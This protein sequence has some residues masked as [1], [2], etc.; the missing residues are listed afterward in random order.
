MSRSRPRPAPPGP[1]STATPID[2]DARGGV[3]EGGAPGNAR[4]GETGMEFHGTVHRI[5][6]GIQ[7]GRRKVRRINCLRVSA[8]T[9]VGNRTSVRPRRVAGA[10][11]LYSDCS[12]A[13]RA[14]QLAH[15]VYIRARDPLHSRSA[16]TCVWLYVHLH[17]SI[18]LVS[19]KVVCA[20]RRPSPNRPNHPPWRGPFRRTRLRSANLPHSSV[21]AKSCARALF[22]F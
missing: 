19:T 3:A 16:H 22:R 9:A 1:P 18:Y 6:F 10:L 21:A 13:T 11:S 20:H 5:P 15:A 12:D 17:G 8:R 14:E 7:P 4:R 2:P